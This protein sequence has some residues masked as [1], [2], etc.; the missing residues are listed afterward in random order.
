MGNAN[1]DGPGVLSS[2]AK[3]A[4][5]NKLATIL[6]A[7]ATA[8]SAGLA[9]LD[10]AGLNVVPWVKAEDLKRVEDDALKRDEAIMRQLKDMDADRRVLMRA[11]WIQKLEEAEAELAINPN[12]RT[13]K[14]LKVEALRA[15]ARL[16]ALEEKP[17]ATP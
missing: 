12:S 2:V 3:T 6:V 16:D 10:A 7:L 4:K 15:I 1:G 13:A 11:F 8:L 9:G 5:E 14:S 17:A